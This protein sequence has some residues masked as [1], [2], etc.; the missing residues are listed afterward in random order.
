FFFIGPGRA[1]SARGD[2]GSPADGWACLCRPGRANRPDTPPCVPAPR[3]WRGWSSGTGLRCRTGPFDASRNEDAPV[4][5]GAGYRNVNAQ[6]SAALL[7]LLV[8]ALLLV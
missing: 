7:A 4:E 3:A 5:G 8:L 1:P 2:G 6:T